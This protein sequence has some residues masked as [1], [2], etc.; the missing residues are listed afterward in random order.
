M[1]P[2]Q[3][4]VWYLIGA[5][6][7]ALLCTCILPYTIFKCVGAATT[8]YLYGRERFNR[9]LEEKKNDANRRT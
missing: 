6:L 7:L 8:G 3:D 9:Y 2:W 1:T 4:V 5:A